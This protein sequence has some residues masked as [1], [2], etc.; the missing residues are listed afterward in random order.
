MRTSHNSETEFSFGNFTDNLGNMFATGPG[1]WLQGWTNFDF[2]L[3]AS[4]TETVL[5]YMIWADTGSEFGVTGISVTQVPSPDF[6]G[7][8]VGDTFQVTV[9]TP[10][11]YSTMIQASTNLVNWVSVY[12]NTVPFTFTDS[13]SVYPQRF[14]RATL[15]AQQQ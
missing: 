9:E 15:V 3:L 8:K 4:Q 1:Q 11:S 14:Y 12:T 2:T 13:C 7:V 10:A 5:S 6:D